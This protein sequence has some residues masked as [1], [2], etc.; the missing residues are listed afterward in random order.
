M[1][2]G[3]RRRAEVL[4]PSSVP[5]LFCLFFVLSIWRGVVMLTFFFCVILALGCSS[6]LRDVCTGTKGGCGAIIIFA[7]VACELLFHEWA[8]CRLTTVDVPL[9]NIGSWA[10]CYVAFRVG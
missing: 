7:L 10:R 9:G 8:K 5:F 1:L 2:F 3:A 4:L 6:G